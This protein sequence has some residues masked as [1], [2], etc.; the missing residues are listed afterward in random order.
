MPKD[1][2]SPGALRDS[3]AALGDA[4]RGL[5]RVMPGVVVVLMLLAVGIV[6]TVALTVHAIVS[7][8]IVIVVLSSLSVF[9]ATRRY[10]ESNLALIVGL[11]TVFTVSWTVPRFIA[12]AA[13]WIAFALFVLL[14]HSIHLASELESIYVDAAVLYSRGGPNHNEIRARLEKIGKPSGGPN[15][16][17]GS[18]DRARVIRR[19]AQRRVDLDYVGAILASANILYTV[20]KADPETITDFVVGLGRVLEGRSTEL[21]ESGDFALDAIT[22]SGT[23]PADFFA[24]FSQARHLVEDG[25]I[26]PKQFLVLL[27]Q[28]LFRGIGPDGIEAYI[29]ERTE[30]S[31]A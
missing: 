20:T 10:G 12:F 3:V 2:S 26:D 15:R 28:G 18:V 21:L 13:A 6:T 29:K 11:F 25:A 23:P 19:A 9:W 1:T 27:Q 24:S 17:L 22:A 4:L 31:P 7:I 8:L 16:L 5:N 14:F 30:V